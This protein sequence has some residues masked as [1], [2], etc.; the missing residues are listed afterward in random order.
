MEDT[1]QDIKR[2]LK[3]DIKNVLEKE[4]RPQ[5][6]LEKESGT[7]RWKLS[8][9]TDLIIILITLTAS[10]VSFSGF[11]VWIWN[12]THLD[13]QNMNNNKNSSLAEA[14]SG[15][16]KSGNFLD[17]YDPKKALA[18]KPAD[19]AV[20]YEKALKFE[21]AEKQEMIARKI[22]DLGIV[23]KR[24][25]VGKDRRLQAM[26]AVNGGHDDPYRI[27]DVIAGARIMGIF[28]NKV[29]LNLDGKRLILNQESSDPKQ[30]DKASL[31][32]IALVSDMEEGN[33]DELPVQAIQNMGKFVGN[34]RLVIDS[35][36]GYKVTSVRG[37][38]PL[39]GAGLQEGDLLLS[40]NAIPLKGRSDILRAYGSIKDQSVIPIEFER[41]GKIMRSDV[42]L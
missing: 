15:E 23:L 35:P 21:R 2:S 3:Q 6:K 19:R 24:T 22:S 14:S 38:D 39:S 11:F 30:E 29:V 34:S 31:P 25:E 28:P 13:L 18:M 8:R 9:K 41:D 16:Y 36:H 12:L 33:A 17:V 26:M 20:L 27:G 32:S 40:I 10:L 5:A 42:R 7:K 37:G 1:A 4:I